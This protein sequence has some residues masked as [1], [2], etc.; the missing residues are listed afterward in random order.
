MA[1]SFKIASL[2]PIAHR[3]AP[4]VLLRMRKLGWLS[5]VNCNKSIRHSIARLL[6]IR[7]SLFTFKVCVRRSSSTCRFFTLT[8]DDDT[9]STYVLVHVVLF[10][11]N[12]LICSFDGKNSVSSHFSLSLLFCG[13]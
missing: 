10:C 8:V 1:C 11:K 4:F 13:L 9:L 2:I 3:R 12:N 7:D 6:M 5:K